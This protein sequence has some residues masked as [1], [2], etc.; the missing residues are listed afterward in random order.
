M[1][2]FWLLIFD[3]ASVTSVLDK[4]IEILNTF[5]DT[6]L[7]S[8]P[9][10]LKDALFASRPSRYFF[11]LKRHTENP[12]G[13]HSEQALWLD[14]S[15][16]HLLDHIERQ[17]LMKGLRWNWC[18][19]HTYELM[20]VRVDWRGIVYREVL[21]KMRSGIGRSGGSLLEVKIPE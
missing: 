12:L 15:S 1:R 3:S 6:N 17:S 7:M 16:W 5:T 13:A 10:S 21:V 2:F 9:N 14:D 18:V 20:K 19:Q 8:K 11:P 4:Y